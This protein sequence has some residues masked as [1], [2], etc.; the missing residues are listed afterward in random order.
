[1]ICRHP[2]FLCSQVVLIGRNHLYAGIEKKAA[3]LYKNVLY[4]DDRAG[5]IYG[6]KSFD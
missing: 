6:S 1:M 4:N 2:I 5:N 3:F